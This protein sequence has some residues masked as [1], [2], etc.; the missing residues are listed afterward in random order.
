MTSVADQAWFK[1]PALQRVLTLLN[2]DGGAARVAGG[3]V[4][5]SLLGMAAGDVDLAG[6]GGAQVGVA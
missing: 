1:D 4:R 6:R 2:A 3:A 5:N